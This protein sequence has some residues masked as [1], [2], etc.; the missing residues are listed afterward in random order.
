[1]RSIDNQFVGISQLD[2]TY[3]NTTG[4]VSVAPRVTSLPC[5]TSSITEPHCNAA[6]S[7]L[8]WPRMPRESWY[9]GGGICPRGCAMGVCYCS[10]A[11]W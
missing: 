9:A 11:T 6:T 3:T 7:R 1:M 4:L 2:D 8:Y 5:T 10:I